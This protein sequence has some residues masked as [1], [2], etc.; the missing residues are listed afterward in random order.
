VGGGLLALVL[1]CACSAA[2]SIPD[3]P[4]GPAAES[5]TL[6]AVHSARLREIM[7]QLDRL[8]S[9]RLPQE[10]D[11]RPERDRR[12]SELAATADAMA[13][14]AERIPGA[15]GRVAL[16]AP[17][18]GLFPMLAEILRDQALELRQRAGADDPR[19]AETVLEQITVTCNACH[20]LFR[21]P[22]R[23]D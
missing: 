16:D 14:A 22:L 20:A 21:Q 17:H 7:R 15:A 19:G 13:G 2:R 12:L 9:D 3:E 1:V 11:V 5:A 8:T 23:A 18:R 6:H 10:M 4:S